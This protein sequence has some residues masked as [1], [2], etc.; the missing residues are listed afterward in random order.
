MWSGALLLRQPLP[1]G[2][3]RICAIQ[4]SSTQERRGEEAAGAL[5]E[6][7]WEFAVVPSGPAAPSWGASARVEGENF[8]Q[9]ASFKTGLGEVLFLNSSFIHDTKL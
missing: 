5:L 1:P 2:S 3:P 6:H 7:P 8:G 4:D 9:D